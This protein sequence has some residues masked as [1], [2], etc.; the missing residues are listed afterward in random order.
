MSYLNEYWR[1]K[2]TDGCPAHIYAGIKLL[3]TVY[4]AE[5]AKQ[6]VEAHNMALAERSHGND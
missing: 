5:S 4:D 1:V 3:A 6:M 2:D